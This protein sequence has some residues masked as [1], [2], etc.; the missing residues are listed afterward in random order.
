MWR[1]YMPALI[2]L[3]TDFGDQDVYVGVMKG[4]MA[5]IAPQAQFI[6]LT[7]TIP[8]QDL[9]AARFNLLNTYRYFP[10]DTIHLA[11]V[12]PGVGTARRAIALATAQGTFVG[13]D[14]GIFSGVLAQ[15]PV[16]R[17]VELANPTYWRTP[18]PS[19]TFHGRDLFAPAAAYLAQGVPLESLG[20]A[21][22]PESLVSLDLPPL[23]I[24]SNAIE[25][26]IQYCDRFG[27]LVTTIPSDRVPSG[28]WY[29][30][31]GNHKIKGGITYGDRPIGSL[32]ALIGSHGWVEL[33]VNE[34][35][36]EDALGGMGEVKVVVRW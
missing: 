12:D 5:A 11:V 27:N 26:T 25:G 3:L 8:P 19:V 33:A 24:T 6:D 10:P 7:H 29:L 15:T 32:I 16:L 35:S 13:P 23:K 18:T 14:N 30:E 2:T 17:A 28:S 9:W 20:P 1:R 36:A 4:V 31:M 34:G 22:A 21:I